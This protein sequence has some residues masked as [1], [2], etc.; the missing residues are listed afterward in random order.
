M[1]L[2]VLKPV[3]FI[4]KIYGFDKLIRRALKASI[5]KKKHLNVI[6]SLHLYKIN[7]ISCYLDSH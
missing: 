6:F 3:Y 7:K 5:L 2:R 1:E 4:D